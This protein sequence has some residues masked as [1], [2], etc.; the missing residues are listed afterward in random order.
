MSTEFFTFEHKGE[1]YTFE[2][3]F[4][5]VRRP[6]W[7]RENRR[8]TPLDMAFTMIEELA[9]DAALEA[10]DDMTDKQFE[11]LSERLNREMNE[12]AGFSG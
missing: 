3:S 1:R 12:G 7:L 2:K 8:R 10:I 6:K 5:V 9:G 11:K 4:D